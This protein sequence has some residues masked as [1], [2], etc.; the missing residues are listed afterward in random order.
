MIRKIMISDESGNILIEKHL[1]EKGWILRAPR[2]PTVPP[3]ETA[4][5]E[6]DPLPATWEDGRDA[7][8]GWAPLWDWNTS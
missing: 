8:L 6:P 3:P 2:I 7:D 5:M 1:D 4:V